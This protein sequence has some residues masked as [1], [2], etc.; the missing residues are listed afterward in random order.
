M[1]E[2]YVLL[3]HA[4]Q[5]HLQRTDKIGNAPSVVLLYGITDNGLHWSMHLLSITVHISALWS[6]DHIYP[7]TCMPESENNIKPHVNRM[8]YFS[9]KL[10]LK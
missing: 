3:I 7:V 6:K 10:S 2:W 8:C 4:Q 5:Q 1:G 9:H